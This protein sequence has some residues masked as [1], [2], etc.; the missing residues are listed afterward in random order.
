MAAEVRRLCADRDWSG[1]ELSRRTGIAQRSV[2]DKLAGR[3]PFDLSDLQRVAGALE[4][5]VTD[6][7]SAAENPP[8]D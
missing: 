5:R 2:T 7:L 6:L 4:V 1:R 3:T 8:K